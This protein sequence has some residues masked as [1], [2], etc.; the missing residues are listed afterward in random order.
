ME[1]IEKKPKTKNAV[2]TVVRKCKGGDYEKGCGASLRLLESDLRASDWYGV[3]VVIFYCPVC[4]LAT[5]LE[6]L[7]SEVRKRVIEKWY[8]TPL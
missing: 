3:P 5:E 6:A 4:S 8:R 2:W 1:I 7:N